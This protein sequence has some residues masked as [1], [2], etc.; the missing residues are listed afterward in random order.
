MWRRR[1]SRDATCPGCYAEVI[2][3]KAEFISEY[4]WVREKRIRDKSP[5]I[6]RRLSQ[7]KD[8]TLREFIF[9]SWGV[10]SK[11]WI[12]VH[13]SHAFSRTRI[14]LTIKERHPRGS[15]V[16]SFMLK[17]VYLA[18]GYLWEIYWLDRR[19][20]PGWKSHSQSLFL[21]VTGYCSHLFCR[22]SPA[23]Y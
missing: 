16:R 19:S 3:V 11:Y 21:S 17:L 15:K 4:I 7:D 14:E 8:K 23:D 20:A 9:I 13:R 5:R 18:L 6:K 12:G 1:V 22:C 2:S 10:Q